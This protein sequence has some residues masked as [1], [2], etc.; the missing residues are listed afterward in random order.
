MIDKHT[1]VQSCGDFTR[2]L[3]YHGCLDSQKQH[4][5]TDNATLLHV[6]RMFVMIL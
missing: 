4:E 5:N 6:R 3:L 2:G 1:S